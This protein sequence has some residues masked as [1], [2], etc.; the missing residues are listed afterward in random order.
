MLPKFEIA[1]KIQQRP[2]LTFGIPEID[3][4]LDFAVD[5][6]AI[7]IASSSKGNG[8]GGYYY[9]HRQLSMR[10]KRP[11]DSLSSPL[12]VI[13]AISPQGSKKL[14]SHNYLGFVL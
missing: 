8:D 5:R 12:P 1:D 6:G 11:A 4:L 2:K 13:V 9:Y 10:K 14:P 7:C 3:C